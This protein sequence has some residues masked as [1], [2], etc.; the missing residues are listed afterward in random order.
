MPEL[1]EVETTMRDLAHHVTGQRIKHVL[2]QSRK[3]RLPVAK[4]FEAQLAGATIVQ[5]T[6]RA[7]YILAEL[8]NGHTLVIHLGMSGR[9]RWYP[10]AKVRDERYAK[11]EHV[12]ITLKDGSGFMFH[13]PRR[14]GLMI[15]VPTA[16]VMQHRLFAH[17]GV[18][19]LAASFT[20][21]KLHDIL[22][23]SKVA[24]KVALL[25]Q[26]RIAGIG[27]IYASEALFYAGIDP[28]RTANSV[29]SAECAKLAPAIKMVLRKSIKA[30][31]SSL[32]DYARTDGGMGH[33][34]D[35]FAVYGR[36]GEPGLKGCGIVEQITQAGRSTF[37]CPGCQS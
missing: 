21:K 18:E 6:R 4:N 8:N 34:Q 29:T 31:G 7:K 19:P 1:P 27:N 14:F 10:K 22:Q 5:L 35:Q 25:D 23:K 30:G 32:R 15:I 11:H 37:W 26:T 28:R 33:F 13:D 16:E 2:V 12:I 3:L 24:V 9:L 20:S 17:I 36:T